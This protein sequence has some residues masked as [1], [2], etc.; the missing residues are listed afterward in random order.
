MNELA[1]AL[2]ERTLRLALRVAGF[3]RSLPDTGE[4]RHV[5]DQLFRSSTGMAANYRASCRARSHREFTAK[6][7]VVLEESDETLFWLAF[8]MHAEIAAGPE[9]QYLLAEG[10]ELLAIFIASVKT[11]NDRQRSPARQ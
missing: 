5:A 1:E 11:A 6:L 3:C 10:R 4:G 9:L 8:V 7:G 2:Q